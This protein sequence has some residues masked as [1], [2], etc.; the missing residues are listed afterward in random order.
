MI[1]K[2][3]FLSQIWIDVNT[4]SMLNTHE[5]SQNYFVSISLN[6]DIEPTC[7]YKASSITLINNQLVIP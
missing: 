5:V 3:F 7:T 2:T 1:E 6:M 4:A